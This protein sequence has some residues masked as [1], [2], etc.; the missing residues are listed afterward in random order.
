MTASDALPISFAFQELRDLGWIGRLH[1]STTELYMAQAG[2]ARCCCP[3]NSHPPSGVHVL[4]R[5][6]DS[7]RY[8]SGDC[9]E[10]SSDD[11][12]EPWS[13]FLRRSGYPVHAGPCPHR[14]DYENGPHQLMRQIRAQRGTLHMALCCCQL[15]RTSPPASTTPL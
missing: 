9:G 12:G 5:L 13:D 11:L 6:T 3:P 7:A 4:I 10:A 8:L 2:A 1:G 15:R 14:S